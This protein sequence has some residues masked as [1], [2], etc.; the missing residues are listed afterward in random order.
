MK[1]APIDFTSL[2]T[3]TESLIY[4]EFDNQLVRIN[5]E[6]QGYGK[7]VFN[8][9]TT[10]RDIIVENILDPIALFGAQDNPIIRPSED[11]WGFVGSPSHEFYAMFSNQFFANE[12]LISSDFKLKNNIRK[13]DD[14]LPSILNLEPVLYQYKKDPNGGLHTGF[15]AQEVQIIYPHL[16]SNRGNGELAINYIELIPL[17]TKSLKDQ[18]ELIESQQKELNTLK[19][20]MKTII[21][22]VGK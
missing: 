2:N 15:I 14:A 8:P 3:D 11:G 16:V 7:T 12:V 9:E 6:L 17:M 22:L 18:Q 1:P 13:I 10:T 19:Q 20:Q 5:G 21:E 4:G